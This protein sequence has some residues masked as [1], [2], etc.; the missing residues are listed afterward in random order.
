MPIAEC[1]VCDAAGDEEAGTLESSAGLRSSDCEPDAGSYDPPAFR[2]VASSLPCRA[3]RLAALAAFGAP[4]WP[5]SARLAPSRFS[6]RP[7]LPRRRSAAARRRPPTPFGLRLR[8]GLGLL[9]LGVRVVLAADQLDLRDLGAVA[10]AVA[11]AQDARVAA[12]P[13]REARRDRVEQLADDVAVRD[14]AQHQAAR[15]QRLAVARRRAARLR[16]AIVM[17]RSTNGRSS[18][19][20]GT[21]VSMRS[22]WMQRGR[23]VAEHRDAMLGDPAEFS[24][25]YSVT[26]CL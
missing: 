2:G 4:A 12:R 22:C 10:A 21:V 20:F 3:C 15:V 25:C 8:G 14:V 1:R 16:L 24:M 11:E 19:A 17:I 9:G 7:S 5:S 18:F 23:L 6:L 26:H 13:R